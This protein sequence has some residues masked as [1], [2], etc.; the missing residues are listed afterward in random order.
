M[1][2]GICKKHLSQVVWTLRKH[3]HSSK[4]HKNWL[5]QSTASFFFFFS[6]FPDS[7]AAVT[8]GFKRYSS[9]I[10]P[11]PDSTCL[12]PEPQKTNSRPQIHSPP[13]SPPNIDPLRIVC[14]WLPLNRTKP[15][16]A[17]Y[18][19][20]RVYFFPDIT[21]HH[22]LV[23]ICR[24]WQI[25]TSRRNP[26]EAHSHSKEEKSPYLCFAEILPILFS[27]L[28]EICKYPWMQPGCS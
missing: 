16:I 28:E 27:R 23:S 20:M 9:I 10:Y 24:V 19:A 4:K 5:L 1:S 13:K 8:R 11:T 17:H 21:C 6:E 12:L 22:H 25:H 26:T 14:C 2:P 7:A 15:T 3:I 18:W